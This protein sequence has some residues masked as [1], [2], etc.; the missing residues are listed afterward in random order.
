MSDQPTDDIGL[1]VYSRALFDTPERATALLEY[2]LEDG[3][4]APQYWGGLPPLRRR[5][6]RLELPDAVELLVDRAKQ[7]ATPETPS[8]EIWL[9]RR[10]RPK[11]RYRVQ[12]IRG[13]HT[14]F[15]RPFYH[16]ESSHVLGSSGL[17]AWLDFCW[18]LL[19]LHDTWFGAACLQQEWD[20][21]NFLTYRKRRLPDW[22]D[23]YK[24]EHGIG[25]DLQN[26]I[27]GVYWGTYFGPF[28]VDWFGR[29]KFHTIPCVSRHDLPTGG[30]FII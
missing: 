3:A 14:P 1:H 26:R 30:V 8:G 10:R 29:A 23:G 16:V 7:E 18:P 12:W 22:P 20:H 9:E 11:A 17:R 24:V 2:L 4:F 19:L 21:H 15:G 25:S 6:T 5:F 27:P 13:P 28:Y